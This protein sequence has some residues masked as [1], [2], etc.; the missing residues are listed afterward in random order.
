MQL[1]GLPKKAFGQEVRLLASPLGIP[2]DR[3]M[4]MHS[5][6]GGASFSTREACV[7]QLPLVGQAPAFMQPASTKACGR[8]CTR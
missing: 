2:V 5:S 6:N 4:H 8:T 7:G 1:Q 3:P